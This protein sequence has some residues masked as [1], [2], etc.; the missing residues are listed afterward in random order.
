MPVTHKTLAPTSQRTQ[1]LSLVK[2]SHLTLFTDRIDVWSEND[3][4]QIRGLEL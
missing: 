2:T 1:F 4:A 3:K